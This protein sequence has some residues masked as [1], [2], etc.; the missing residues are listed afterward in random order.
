M[1]TYKTFVDIGL[2]AKR[3]NMNWNRNEMMENAERFVGSFEKQRKE[4]Q[5]ELLIRA[6]VYDI[7]NPAIFTQLEKDFYGGRNSDKPKNVVA[8]IRL[9]KRM[10]RMHVK[11]P[12]DRTGANKMRADALKRKMQKLG[13]KKP[14][15]EP[16]KVTSVTTSERKAPKEA[17]KSYNL[18]TVKKGH[19]GKN[20]VVKSAGTTKRWY[21]AT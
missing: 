9:S 11:T 14:K 12:I 20:W 5:M 6:G 16:K 3:S 19:D 13:G 4:K 8:M 7:D 17:A 15:A 21:R 10:N 1:E 18:G 2:V